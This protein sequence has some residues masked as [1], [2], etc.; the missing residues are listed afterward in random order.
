[1]H[2]NKAAFWLQTAFFGQKP[3]VATKRS[4]FSAFQT[5]ENKSEIWSHMLATV[6]LN[7]TKVS[8]SASLDSGDK[9][10]WTV[11]CNMSVQTCLNVYKELRVWSEKESSPQAGNVTN[12]WWV[13]NDSPAEGYLFSRGRMEVGRDFFLSLIWTTK[14]WWCVYFRCQLFRGHLPY[15]V[16]TCRQRK[17]SEAQQG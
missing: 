15:L 10:L 7:E 17:E 11:L 6:D 1:M 4:P 9:S 14:H 5:G 13:S 16:L 12:S 8:T 2:L 3:T